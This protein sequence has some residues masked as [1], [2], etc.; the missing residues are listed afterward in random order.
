MARPARN[1]RGGV[2]MKIGFLSL[3]LSGMLTGTISSSVQ[4]GAAPV[5]QPPKKKEKVG[6]VVVE[7]RDRD[8]QENNKGSQKPRS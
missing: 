2:V 6:L 3:V 8:R 7:K 4:A 1:L 5:E